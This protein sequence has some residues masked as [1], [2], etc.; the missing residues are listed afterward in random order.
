MPATATELGRVSDRLSFLHVEHTVVD[1]DANAVTFWQQDGVA[2]VP[3]A[4]LAA[5]LLGPGSKITHAAVS[6]LAG[7]GCSVL[8]TGEE[9]VRLYAGAVAASTTSGLL[10]RQAALVS[11]QRSRLAVARAMYEMR[12]PG[13]DL[14]KLEMQQ[15]RGREGARVRKCYQ[16]WSAKTGVPWHGRSYTVGKWNAASPVNQCLSAANSALYGVCHAALLHLGCSPGLGFVHTG[17]QLSMVYD[18]AD[19]Y[20]AEVTIPVAFQIAAEGGGDFGGR[21][22]R[23]VRDAIVEAR[24][25]G[26]IVADIKQL[27]G[28][29]E[30]EGQDVDVAAVPDLWDG[31]DR[32][33]RGGVGYGGE[34]P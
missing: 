22:R 27:F 13:E 9:G 32:T 6:L 23:A 15:L 3:A 28:V 33:V 30:D 2:S 18:L 26:R 1:R 8:W 11:N 12:F 20:K 29:P 24:L 34:L 25:L 5:L 21:S 14:A 10:L 31:G 4:M 7:S 17:H 19:L 16:E